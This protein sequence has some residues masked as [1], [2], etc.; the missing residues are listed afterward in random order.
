MVTEQIYSGAHYEAFVVKGALIVTHRRKRGGKHFL[1]SPKTA[2]FID[3]IR[4]AI[5]NE[6]AAALCRAL[7]NS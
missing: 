1:A 6:E 2:E 3:A 5:D 4:T 7:L